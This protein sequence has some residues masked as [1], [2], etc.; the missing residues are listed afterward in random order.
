MDDSQHKETYTR[1]VHE[2]AVLSAEIGGARRELRADLERVSGKLLTKVPALVML[3]NRQREPFM[4]DAKSE[5]NV[6]A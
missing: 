1:T 2:L 3:V 5:G 4:L 6:H